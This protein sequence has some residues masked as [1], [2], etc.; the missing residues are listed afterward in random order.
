M[1]PENSSVASCF[2]DAAPRLFPF[3]PLGKIR[4]QSESMKK[5][6]LPVLWVKMLGFLRQVA[7]G[8]SFGFLMVCLACGRMTAKC[9]PR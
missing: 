2:A 7:L 5:S 8:A 9:V 6:R 1:L 3:F 4:F